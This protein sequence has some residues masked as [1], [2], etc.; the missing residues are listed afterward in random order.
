LKRNW[1]CWDQAAGEGDFGQPKLTGFGHRRKAPCL[2][3]CSCSERR[4][5]RERPAAQVW[6]AVPT[7]R[8]AGPSRLRV[9]RILRRQSLNDALDFF[10]LAHSANLVRPAAEGKR[11]SSAKPDPTQPFSSL[12]GEPP[13][14]RIWIAGVVQTPSTPFRLDSAGLGVPGPYGALPAAP[15]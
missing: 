12:P 6:L 5:D 11:Q 15:G 14:N 10:D 13:P 3:G 4:Y 2:P 9:S 1:A 7:L 8:H